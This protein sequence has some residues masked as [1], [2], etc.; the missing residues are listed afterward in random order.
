MKLDL[1]SFSCLPTTDQ[2][3]IIKHLQIRVN[4]APVVRITLEPA[5]PCAGAH[6]QQQRDFGQPVIL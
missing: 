3:S 1:H 2:F 6:I 5:A 4:G